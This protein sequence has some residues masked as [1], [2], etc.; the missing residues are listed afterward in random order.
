MTVDIVGIGDQKIEY[1]E[2]NNDNFD[3][4][5]EYLTIAK[6]TIRT[7]AA[8]FR[9][10]LSEEMLRSDDAISNIAT[11]IMLADWRWSAD[12]R[13]KKGTVR[14]KRAYRNQCVIWAISGY[15]SR[16]VNH[17]YVLSL[18]ALL[19]PTNNGDNETTNLYKVLESNQASPD[20][21]LVLQENKERLEKLLKKV[22]LTDNQDR[23]IRMR[24]MENM[25]LQQIATKMKTSREAVRQTVNRAMDNI[26]S[27]IGIEV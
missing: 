23:C 11:H 8:R 15:V 9:V 25:T 16:R 12:Y 24:H 10:G 18:D 17:R 26:H 6:K 1:P 14:T 7:F 2:V 20:S 21:N 27:S 19:S 5:E 22:C 13:S 3:T 4:M